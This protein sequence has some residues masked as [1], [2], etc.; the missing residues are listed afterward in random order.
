MRLHHLAL[1]AHALDAVLGFYRDGLG[2]PELRRQHEADGALRSV[3]LGAEGTVLM[4]EQAAPSEPA[5]AAHTLELVA[6]AVTPEQRDAL[7]AQLAARGTLVE[8]R[9]QHTVYVRDPE[10][11]RV[12]LSSYP[13]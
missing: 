1:R 6:F 9:T 4:L 5:I 7:E 11:R 8:A 12:G 13:F 2:L 3:W 10:G